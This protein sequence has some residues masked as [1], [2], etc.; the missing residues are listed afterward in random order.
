MANILESEVT[1]VYEGDQ[2]LSPA[3]VTKRTECENR[4][5]MYGKEDVLCYDEKI[6]VSDEEG[7]HSEKN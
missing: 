1:V 3:D 6:V 4:K 2:I 5:R 7:V